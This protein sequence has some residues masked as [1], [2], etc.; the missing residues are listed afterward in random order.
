MLFNSYVFILMFLPITTLLFG[1]IAQRGQGTPTQLILVTASLFFYG[2]WNPAYLTL[3]AL[4]IFFNY[5]MCIALRARRTRRPKALLAFAVAV[6]L[7][8]LAYYKYF[9]WL[10]G[11]SI[12]LPLAISF[13]TFQQIA[14]LVDAFRHRTAERPHFV[15]YVSCVTF[16]PHLIA[17][18]LVNYR[19]LYPQFAHA[20]D[21]RL[22]A[23]NVAVGLAVF[24]I[25]LAKKVLIADLFK[26][27]ADPVFDSGTNLHEVTFVDAWIATLSYTFQIYFDFSGYSDMAIGL[28]RI[29]G[30]TLP[31]NFLSP[32]QAA[33]VSEFWKRWHI[34]LSS[35][36]RDYL[37]IPLG[38]NRKG[39]LRQYLNLAVTMLLGGLWHG[40]GWGFVVWGALHG[41]YLCVNH[42]ARAAV[43]IRSPR[44]LKVGVTF[45][46]AA[47]AWVFFRAPSVEVAWTLLKKMSSPP[48]MFETSFF[49]GTARNAS[50]LWLATAVLVFFGPNVAQ[51]FRKE[52]LVIQ[53]G[54]M[55]EQLKKKSTFVFS[56]NVLS[57]CVIA[58]LLIVS[59][60]MISKGSH[61]IYYQF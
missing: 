29:F 21:L 26:G 34:T 39:S 15:N 25:G 1:L 33:S 12:E 57:A 17:G 48:G 13:F 51:I 43:Q 23:R 7:S 8:V 11:R 5:A 58:A 22:R 54:E 28:S 18:P 24:G 60:V 9:P 41:F 27:F 4:S 3:L 16:F 30:I 20:K 37:Y 45:L 50:V 59:L 49:I 44:F 38:G 35:F 52:D 61:F 14:F 46:A 40:A 56:F 47:I 10:S 55:L 53:G 2:W 42:Y 36:L 32:Y 19:D 6:N 31:A